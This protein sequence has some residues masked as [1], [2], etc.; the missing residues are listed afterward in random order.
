MS[1][2]TK[3][4][5]E[6]QRPGTGR[7]LSFLLILANFVGILQRRFCAIATNFDFPKVLSEYL[8]TRWF[9]FMWNLVDTIHQKSW[10]YPGKDTGSLPFWFQAFFQ[11]RMFERDLSSQHLIKKSSSKE[12][13]P[14]WFWRI[15]VSIVDTMLYF[16]SSVLAWLINQLINSPSQIKPRLNLNRNPGT[17]YDGAW[18]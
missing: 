11:T 10:N 13:K 7:S 12:P 18:G 5:L 9:H 14:D 16:G 6:K 2:P 1:N 4:G 17:F 8:N 15:S 3:K